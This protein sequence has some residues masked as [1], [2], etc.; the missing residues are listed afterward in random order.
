MCHC[1]LQADRIEKH[2]VR[3]GSN[4]ADSEGLVKVGKTTPRGKYLLY[5]RVQLID[6]IYDYYKLTIN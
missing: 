6:L 2:D 4:A 5:F 3:K 1:W